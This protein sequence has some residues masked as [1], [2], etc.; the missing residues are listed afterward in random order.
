M[1]R[2]LLPVVAAA[3]AMVTARP[4]LAAQACGITP[5]LLVI[6]DRSASMSDPPSSGATASKWSTAS[7]V[8]PQVLGTYASGFDYGLMM[9]PGSPSTDVCSVGVSSLGVGASVSQIQQKYTGSTPAG[10]TP[11]ATTL[12]AARDYLSSLNLSVPAYVLL[13]TDGQPNCN[14]S[15]DGNTCTCTKS[16]YGC[17][18]G[19]GGTSYNCLDD[20]RTE[21]AAAQVRAAG[22]PVY[23]V[24]FGAS[25]T[26]DNNAAVLDAIASS[27]GTNHSYSALST[28]DLQ[29]AL[30]QIVGGVTGCCTNACTPGTYDCSASGALKKCEVQ[31]S[32]CYDWSTYP[33]ANGST[34]QGGS[35]QACNST[36]AA[37]ATQ[38]SGSGVQTCVADVNGCT[39]WNG[40]SACAS[41]S[42]CSGGACQSCSATCVAGARQC[43]GDG[44]SQACVADANGCTSWVDEPCTAGTTCS[45]GLCTSCNGCSA[46][47]VQCAGNVP[48]TCV[49]DGQGCT[50]WQSGTPCAGA[51]VCQGGACADCTGQCNVGDSRCGQSGIETCQAQQNVC[52]AWVAGLPCDTGSVC[53][54]GACCTPQCQAGQTRCGA[55]GTI[56]TCDAS[57]GCGVWASSGCPSGQACTGGQCLT[58][59]NGGEVGDCPSGEV[60]TETSDGNFCEPGTGGSS[61]SGS[62]GGTTGSTSGATSGSSGSTGLA[63]DGTGGSSGSPAQSHGG[64]MP[65]GGCSCDALPASELGLALPFVMMLLARRRRK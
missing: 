3:M 22:F 61:S 2:V 18:P 12:L 29:A 42:V 16:T 36:C 48:L 27:G 28:G 55:D 32:G 7:S 31:A 19:S 34:C 21:D 39:S 4:A 59:C 63:T 64:D 13:I 14:G 10:A 30:N 58:P 17:L 49:A 47:D 44:L 11:M 57:S 24:G 40:G 37:G 41:G 35:C 46:G 5:V 52:N 43:A 38:C 15:L 45:G 8:V 53:V 1:R 6:Q 54:N 56:Q 50:S 25:S 9:F 26:V 20:T 65:K 60:C 51:S 62:T 23:V 33:C